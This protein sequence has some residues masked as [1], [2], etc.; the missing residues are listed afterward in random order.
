M[1]AG[2]AEGV[3]VQLSRPLLVIKAPKGVLA[4]GYLNKDALD[5]FGD[6]AAIVTGV[7]SFDDMLAAE[8]AWASAAARVAGV[9]QGMRGGEALELMF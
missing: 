8:V 6:V 3:A 1:S 2:E 9:R 7:S 5:K 4:C